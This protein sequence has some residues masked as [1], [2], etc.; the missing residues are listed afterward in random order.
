MKL[1]FVTR[2]KVIACAQ[3]SQVLSLILSKPIK[4][5]KLKVKSIKEEINLCNV[6]TLGRGIKR[7]SG[8]PSLQVCLGGQ[9]LSVFLMLLPFNPV[10]HVVVIYHNILLLLH[11]CSFTAVMTCKYLIHIPQSGHAH[12]WRATCSRVLHTRVSLN[13][14]HEVYIYLV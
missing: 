5:S 4:R 9:W 7:T 14:R 2:H 3:M 6:A 8:T 10:P 1:G 11:N 13:R 12:M